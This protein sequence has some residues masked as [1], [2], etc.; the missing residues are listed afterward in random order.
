MLQFL[1]VQW[2]HDMTK[3]LTSLEISSH[4]KCEDIVFCANFCPLCPPPPVGDVIWILS[5]KLFAFEFIHILHAL[6]AHP[7]P[8]SL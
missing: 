8:I 6:S 2:K 3:V 4:V 5:G 1:P 7:F